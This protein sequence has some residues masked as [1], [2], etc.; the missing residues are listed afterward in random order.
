MKRGDIY[1]ARLDPPV[2]ARPVLI[3][4]RTSALLAR[5][6]VTVA[7]ITTR[8]REI[9]SE[10][11]VGNAEGLARASVALC[12]NLTTIQKGKLD[13]KPVGRL[14]RSRIP[15]LDA[16]ICFALGISST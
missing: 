15:Q 4:T 8:I 3:V 6:N 14:T 10:V 11:P 7:P 9:P 5:L 2:G 16:A 1:W 13:P 12:D